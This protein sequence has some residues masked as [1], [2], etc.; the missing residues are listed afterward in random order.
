MSEAPAGMTAVLSHPFRSRLKG[1]LN[2]RFHLLYKYLPRVKN[3][4]FWAI[5]GLVIGIA[6]THYIIE[7]G[8]YLPSL[9]MLY[10]VPISLFFVPVVYAALNFGFPGA[11]ATALWATVITIP[12]FIFWHDG[13]ERLGVIFQLLIVNAVAVFVGQ[14]VDRETSSR[15]RAEEARGELKT[16]ATH[17]VQAQ[18]DERQRIARELHD[19]TIQS[20][21]LLCRRL[22]S[23][24]TAGKGLPST[25]IKELREARKITEAVV[26]ELRDFARDLRPTTL[27]DLGI[28]TS[29]R[30]LLMDSAK[31]SSIKGQIKLVG[32]ERR[33]PRDVAVGLFRIAQE[34]LWNVE[35]HSRADEV[36]V[37][38]IFAKREA[39]LRVSDNGAGF[40][41]PAILGSFSSTG[42]LGLI[43]ARER[44]ELL[45][46]KLEVKSSP[47]NGTAVTASIPIQEGI[48]EVSDQ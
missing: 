43:G 8:G 7:V 46:G 5:Q 33:L 1:L 30:R 15:R 45:G 37:A 27:D 22:D 34:A 14:R 18:E 44:A 9:G 26:K 41:V 28:V 20:L 32:E 11:L 12:N 6:G 10:F 35:R 48:S 16:Y 31:R 3:W 39:T 17:L 19:K 40:K 47:Q 4:H 29:I 38:I 23:V 24:E 25:V 42:R 2:K 36:V 13:L 21:A